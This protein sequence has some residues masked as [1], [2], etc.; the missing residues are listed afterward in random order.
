MQRLGTRPQDYLGNCEPDLNDTPLFKQPPPLPTMTIHQLS[1]IK[2]HTPPPYSYEESEEELALTD[3]LKPMSHLPV[4][5]M[6]L[7][8]TGQAPL[9]QTKTAL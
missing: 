1:S 7:L 8:A 2:Q 4:D 9:S 3:R 5:N 6:R